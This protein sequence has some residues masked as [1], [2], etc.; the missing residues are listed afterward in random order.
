MIF[1][2]K[3]LSLLARFKFSFVPTSFYSNSCLCHPITYICTYVQWDYKLDGSQDYVSAIFVNWWQGASNNTPFIWYFYLQCFSH[4]SLNFIFQQAC[5]ICIILNK[6]MF[7]EMKWFFQVHRVSKWNLNT[8][9][10]VWTANPV[11]FRERGSQRQS[12]RWRL[13]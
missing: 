12:T 4:I 1:F 11:P 9:S 2:T 3:Y 7:E 8:S 13:S 10:G 6:Q 5:K